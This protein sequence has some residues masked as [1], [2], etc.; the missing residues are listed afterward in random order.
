MTTKLPTKLSTKLS[1][2][3]DW[4]VFAFE[5][6]KKNGTKWRYNTQKKV[7]NTGDT[8]IAKLNDLE[9]LIDDNITLMS[10]KRNLKDVSMIFVNNLR[11]LYNELHKLDDN[12]SVI[13][14]S[15]SAIGK[16]MKYKIHTQNE[17]LKKQLIEDMSGD[18]KT[19]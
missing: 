16:I 12:E 4:T 1:T 15:L 17:E 11:G 19:P 9:K 3:K 6:I 7:F 13:S 18:Q 10:K 2:F 8:N 14:Q 5:H